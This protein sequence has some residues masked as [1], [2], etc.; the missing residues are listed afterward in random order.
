MVITKQKR[1]STLLKNFVLSQD[2]L[3]MAF[4]YS[5][6]G[7]LIEKF[8]K[9]A[10]TTLNDDDIDAIHGAISAQIESL[11]ERISTEYEIGS[12]GTGS[13]ET[14]DHR[15]IYL[16]AGPDAILLCV[17]S[18]H[19]DLNKLFTVA[20]L[21][22]EKIAEILEDSFDPKYQSLSI[23]DLKIAD[24]YNLKLSN[25]AVKD[26]EVEGE[27]IK[28]SHHIQTTKSRPRYF[29]L[30]LLGSK[31]VGKTTLV[32]SFLKNERVLDY[33]PTL[34]TA[35][36]KKDYYLQGFK[37]DKVKFL[38]YDLA[39]QDFFKRVRHDYYEGANCAFIVY[40]VTRPETF[41][42]ALNFW[43]KDA[44][45]ELGNIPF[46]LVG[47]KIDLEDQREVSKEEGFT[48]SEKIRSLFIETSAL[49]NVNV[50]DAFKLIGIDLVFQSLGDN[51]SEGN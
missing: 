6:E 29:K 32:N 7:L 35:I 9:I 33:R 34:G 47:N 43:Y 27:N 48:Q 28:M 37:D 2:D 1:L 12:F 40:D 11:L 50:Q 18:Y 31:A 15:I 26:P 36:S 49:E 21:V 42:E 10:E 45:K 8:G 19:T 41:D 44:R 46:V 23:P 5:R 25:F 24:D 22:V 4:I 14:P 39:G 51:L 3:Q 17:C 38:I 13:F 20:Y 16:E 30:I